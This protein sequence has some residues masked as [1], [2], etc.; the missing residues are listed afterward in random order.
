MTEILKLVLDDVFSL[1]ANDSII[2]KSNEIILINDY[3]LHS[4]EREHL[5]RLAGWHLDSLRKKSEK[6]TTNLPLHYLYYDDNS[7]VRLSPIR[8]KFW[9]EHNNFALYFPEGSKT[10]TFIKIDGKI[11]EETNEKRIKKYVLDNLKENS[12]AGDYKYFDYM[13]TKKEYFTAEF[14]S[15]L[16]DSKVEFQ[17]DTPEI[18]YLYYQ[19]CMVKV[20]ADNVEII[21][22]KDVDNY[23]WKN[24]IIPRSYEK[25]DHKESEFRH[26]MYCVSGHDMVKYKTLQSVVGYLLHGYKNK[27]N[28][29]AIILNDAVISENPN[30]GSGKGLFCTGIGH[31]KKLDSLNGKDV[32]F[33]SQFQNQTVR[34]DC[35]VLVFEDVKRNFNFENLF[36]VI[37]EGITIE[38]K[39]QPAVK[40]SVE[41]SPKIV[42]TTNHT[43]G[44][45]GGSHE[46]RKFE[47]EF[48][49][50]FN[51]NHSPLDYFK[52]L[53]FDEWDKTDWSKFDNF[54]IKCVQVYL[55]S[56][57]IKCNYDNIEVK[58][59]IRNVGIQ[60]YEWTKNHDFME[61]GVKVKK[62]ELWAR[63]FEDYPDSKHWYYDAKQV[64]CMELYCKYYGFE[65][66]ANNTN[67]TQKIGRFIVVTRPNHDNSDIPNVPFFDPNESVF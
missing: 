58:K 27:A 38:Y 59:F 24:Q 14:L 20:T 50:F 10:Y 15:M 29:R 25:T 66:Y 26:F 47:V 2:L 28:N 52:R 17:Q 33:K 4:K 61:Y 22:Y 12:V 65:Y 16:E 6:E 34:M 51:E 23:V 31:M 32:D 30:G 45:V 11:I 7:K 49:A 9:L 57:L 40:L 64:L 46:R 41:K 67:G 39:N 1:G 48:C 54:M 8:Y 60:F 21:E 62:S 13:S 36:S 63:F 18:C 53:L 42:I 44:G 5:R 55:K 56:G 37:T 35:Q 43:I 3:P 19:N